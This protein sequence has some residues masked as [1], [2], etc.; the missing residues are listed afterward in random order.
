MVVVNTRPGRA[1][2]PLEDLIQAIGMSGSFCLP[3]TGR[4]VGCIP[5]RT[6]PRTNGLLS[7]ASGKLKGAS[8][9]YIMHALD[10]SLKRLRTEWIDL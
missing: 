3:A 6:W 2:S 4:S 5:S 1:F 8:R 9:R 7:P 10:A